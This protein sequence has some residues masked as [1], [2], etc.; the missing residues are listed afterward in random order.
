VDNLTNQVVDD[1]DIS[2]MDLA[3]WFLCSQR[4]CRWPLSSSPQ[5]SKTPFL[6]VWIVYQKKAKTII[7]MTIYSK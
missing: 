4:S 7:L 5:V 2:V 6:T 1:D 3:A